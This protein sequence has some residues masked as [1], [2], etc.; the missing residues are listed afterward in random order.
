LRITF[1]DIIKKSFFRDLDWESIRKKDID[2]DEIPYKPNP[3]KY[4][5]LLE[6]NYEETSNLVRL[7]P[8]TSASIPG[9][10]PCTVNEPESAS[11]PKKRL[12]GDFTIYKVNKEFDNF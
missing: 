2:P 1:K 4:K 10:T 6:N 3:N 11:S 7:Q 8:G 12:L 9:Q 5:Y